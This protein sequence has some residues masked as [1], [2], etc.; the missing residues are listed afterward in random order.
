MRILDVVGFIGRRENARM[1]VNATDPI[2]ATYRF[3]NMRREDDRVTKWIA[4]HWR[5]PYDHDPDLWFAMCVARMALNEIESMSEL[6]VPLPWNA[7]RFLEMVRS[8]QERKLRVYNPAYMIATPN[9]TG[10]KHEFLV[11]RLLQ[12]MWDNR[13]SI[14]PTMDDTLA[15]FFAR[16]HG[17][18]GVGTFTAAQVVADMKYTTVLRTASDWWTWAAPGPGSRRGLN[19]VFGYPVNQ[20]W[21]DS[22][23]LEHLTR[24]LIEVNNWFAYAP[25]HA[26]DMQNVMCEFDKYERAR[27]GEGKP[28]QK[29][30]PFT[31][32]GYVP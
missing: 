4:D 22:V 15:A 32:Q 19:R 26:Q 28:K 20:A 6:G 3:C 17:C 7:D 31:A 10:P 2:I 16:L 8:R 14:R 5:T 27:L 29:Y 12:P 25:F 11:S 21:H 18:Y 23:F 9:W 13:A 1:R 30:V 24:L